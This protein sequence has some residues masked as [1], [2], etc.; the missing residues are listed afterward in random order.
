MPLS[1]PVTFESQTGIF[2]ATPTQTG[3]GLLA[4]PERPLG[5]LAISTLT[6]SSTIA[7]PTRSFIVSQG[8]HPRRGY[9]SV[10]M[11]PF[12]IEQTEI[13]ALATLR[14]RALEEIVIAA[15]EPYFDASLRVRVAEAKHEWQVAAQQALDEQIDDDALA[16]VRERAAERLG[17]L[18]AE[19]ESINRQLRMTTD[20]VIELPAVVI[21]EPEVDDKRARQASLI[22]SEWTW[23]E[24]TRALVARKAYGDL[25]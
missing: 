12:Q 16:A 20:R 14:P 4:T 17:E 6:G 2:I 22:S 11:S 13:D 25:E 5:G 21:P 15:I 23:A 24:A 1:L 3:H 10:L 8:L 18:E 9:P 7:T 19:V